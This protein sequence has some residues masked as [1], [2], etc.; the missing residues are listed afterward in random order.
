MTMILDGIRVLDWT[1]F[2]QGPV[3]GMMLGDM[4]A[5][6]IKIEERVGGDVGRGMLKAFGHK[7]SGEEVGRS[8]YFEAHNRNK[9]SVTI[10]LGKDAGREVVYKLVEKSDVFLHNFRMGVAERVGLD[11]DTLIKYNPRLVYAHGSGWGPKGPDAFSPSA[12]YTGMARSGIMNIAGE[13]DDNPVQIHGGIAD[14]LGGI[15]TAFGVVAALLSR[16]RTGEGQKVDTSLLGS[17]AFLLGLPVNFVSLA[18]FSSMRIGRKQAGNPLWNHYRCG[19]DK[20]LALACLQSDKF[21]PGVCRAIGSPELEGDPRFNN[22]ENRAKNGEE[23]VTLLDDTFASKPQDEW[24]GLLKANDVLFAP[25][26]TVPEMMN[27]PQTLVN[28]YVKEIDH[29]AWGKVKTTGFPLGFNKT[30]CSIRMEAPEFGQHTEL[31]L[32]D[33]LGYS[34]DDIAKLKEA[35]VI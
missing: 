11:Y 7:V 23:L 15:M 24:L 20:W 22:I 28:D 26:N 1:I 14:Q 9:M 13:P 2:Q 19:D 35:E 34:W 25:V 4:G 5:E 3:A 6:V 12:D 30:P 27:D 29:S 33:L 32:A 31:I 10:D 16:E 21:W 8:P 17:M 18:G